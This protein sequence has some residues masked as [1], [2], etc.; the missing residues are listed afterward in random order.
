MSLL[1]ILNKSLDVGCKVILLL[2]ALALAL[3]PIPFL[4]GH[5][6]L[7]T[8]PY[9]SAL[10]QHQ[11]RESELRQLATLRVGNLFLK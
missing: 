7:H 2:A 11:G 9:Y 6:A 8:Q 5:E 3:L 10:D 4:L 1:G